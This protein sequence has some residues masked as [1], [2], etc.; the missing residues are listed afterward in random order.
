MHTKSYKQVHFIITY[1]AAES[2]PFW[3][4]SG[5]WDIKGTLYKRASIQCDGMQNL[6]TTD[7]GAHL[8]FAHVSG[9]LTG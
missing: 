2:M 1:K 4:E 3:L 9:I 5:E 8:V 6:I 7:T